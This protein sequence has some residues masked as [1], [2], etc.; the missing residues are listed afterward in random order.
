MLLDIA[1]MQYLY[2]A[3]MTWQTSNNVYSWGARTRKFSTIW[4]AGGTNTLS[5]ANRVAK[6]TLNLNEGSFSSIGAVN[7]LA[8]AYN[9]KIGK[10]LGYAFRQYPHR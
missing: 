4:D 9:A 6:V 5:A 1:A 7:N 10:R 2:G 8:I 3:N